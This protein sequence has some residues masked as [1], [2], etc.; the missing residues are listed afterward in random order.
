[1]MALNSVKIDSSMTKEQ[2]II[3]YLFIDEQL[4]C[5]WWDY[6]EYW[7]YRDANLE[8]EENPEFHVKMKEIMEVVNYWE[9]ILNQLKEIVSYK[10]IEDYVMKNPEIT[11][12][13]LFTK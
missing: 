13:Y 7:N 11:K 8:P 9:D 12:S 6:L 5:S 2:A 3:Y 10:D 1:M 4:M